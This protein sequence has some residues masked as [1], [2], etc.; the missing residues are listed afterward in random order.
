MDAVIESGGHQYLVK[1]GS[2]L[3]VNRLVAKEGD[4][5]D[6]KVLSLLGEA[7]AF[8]ASQIAGK[9]AKVKV[10]QHLRGDK[11]IVAKYKRRKGY[12]K[13]QGHR[14]ELTKIEIIDVT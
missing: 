3:N 1:K 10:L 6:V 2:V 11:I 7:P 9:K 5:L 12:H 4:E 13:K 8:G 14:Q